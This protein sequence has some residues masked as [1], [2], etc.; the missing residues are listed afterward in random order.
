MEHGLGYE[1]GGVQHAAG[2]PIV[3]NREIWKRMYTML[4]QENPDSLIMGHTSE[5]SCAPLLSFCD[6]WL[7][8]E[9]NWFGQLRDD[10]LEA[11][12]LDELRAEFRAQHFGGIPW[13]LPAWQRAAVLED[14]DVVQRSQDGRV[15]KVT[16]EKTHHMFG[17][18]LLLDIGFWPIQG[19]ELRGA[20][21][22]VCRPG[23]VRH[24]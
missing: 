23:R 5:N 20:Q 3:A 21:T 2:Y 4:R 6:I 13:W 16:V 7:C 1:R 22:V 15:G 11:L 24:E 9:G 18:A 8:G 17:I 12:P 10:Y 19:D 14:K